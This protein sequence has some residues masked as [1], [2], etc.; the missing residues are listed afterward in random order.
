MPF[1][2]NQPQ[3]HTLADAVQM[4]AQLNAL[5]DKIDAQQGQ[6]NALQIL[7]ES[8]QSQITALQAQVAALPPGVTQAQ[9]DQEVC[10]LHNGQDYCLR[11]LPNYRS[12]QVGPLTLTVSDPPTQAEVQAILDKENQYITALSTEG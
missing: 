6:I 11:N 5:N 1:D 10:I 7:T 2:P 9:F 8:Q 3:P 4:R 12:Q